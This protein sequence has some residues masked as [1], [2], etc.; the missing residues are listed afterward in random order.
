MVFINIIFNFFVEKHNVLK[1]NKCCWQIDKNVVEYTRH[2]NCI[3]SNQRRENTFGKKCFLLFLIPSLG[4]HLCDNKLRGCIFSVRSFW[5]ALF[6]FY[7][8]KGFSQELYLNAFLIIIILQKIREC[9]KYTYFKYTKFLIRGV[10]RWEKWNVFI[11]IISAR[12]MNMQTAVHI[13]RTC[14]IIAVTTFLWFIYK[15]KCAR[16][17][18]KAP[19]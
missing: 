15:V 14:R 11:A 7:M 3:C 13:R 6:Y 2:T 10:E 19:R 8:L 4:E 1:A 17:L 18:L 9:C 16:I 12:F 5:G